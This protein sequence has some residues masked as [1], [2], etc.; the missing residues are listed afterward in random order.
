MQT[1]KDLLNKLGNKKSDDSAKK[2]MKVGLA[3]DDGSETL[4][5]DDRVFTDDPAVLESSR[6]SSHMG[7]LGKVDEQMQK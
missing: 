3:R 2:E 6:P 5:V 1:T 7:R 4:N